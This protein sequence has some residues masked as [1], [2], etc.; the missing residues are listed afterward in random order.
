MKR[1]KIVCSRCNKE[2]KGN[3]HEV[4][5]QFGEYICSQCHLG[6]RSSS[7]NDL[8]LDEMIKRYSELKEQEEKIKKEK[9]ELHKKIK[10]QLKDFVDTDDDDGFSREDFTYK[11]QL[12]IPVNI[13]KVCCGC[14]TL[15]VS[16]HQCLLDGSLHF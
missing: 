2:I 12:S 16:N 9:E 14:G 5:R 4:A 15:Y 7:H 11:C 1:D 13:M 6:I 8:T 3:D 10:E